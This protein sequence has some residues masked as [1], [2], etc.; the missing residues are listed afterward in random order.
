MTVPSLSTQALSID[1]AGEEA[2]GS[3]QL[4]DDNS[5]VVCLDGEKTHI[6]VPC[7]HQCVCAP[8]GERLAAQTGG[9]ARYPVCRRG[10]QMAMQVFK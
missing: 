4:G 7:G 2:T 9:G 8:C 1:Q 3:A 5:C 6:L 10:I